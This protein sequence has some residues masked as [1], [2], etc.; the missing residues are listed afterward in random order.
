MTRPR[1]LNRFARHARWTGVLAT[2]FSTLLAA[3][4]IPLPQADGS[5]LVLD[6][7]AQRVI[8]LAPHLAELAWAA[9]AGDT[10]VGTVAWSDFPE[11]VKQLPEIGDAFRFDLERILA[12]RPNL[13][14]GWASGNPAPALAGIEELGLPVWRVEIRTPRDIAAVMEALGKATGNTESADAAADDFRARLADLTAR[15][16]GRKPVS[17]FYQVAEQPL[18]TLTGKHLVS[19]ALALC[20]GV[21]I[22]ADLGDIAP[23]V[24]AEAVIAADPAVMFAGRFEG[25]GEP[26]AHWREWP[27]L[28][29]V[30][31]DALLYLPADEI[32]RATPRMLDAVGQACK[33][34]DDFRA[35]KPPTGKGR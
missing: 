18:Y 21:N 24:S 26:L 32:N 1:S 17:Y 15:Y 22:F 9:G 14:L 35:D 29:A 11:P 23:Q 30:S 25:S 7:P 33:L 16:A 12:L 5:T 4:H 28:Q 31:H 2:L 20:G 8:T 27:R 3:D 6:T 34:L 10:L 13:V 19:Q